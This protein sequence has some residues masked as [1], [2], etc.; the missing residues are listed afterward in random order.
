[1]PRPGDAGRLLKGPVLA[2][3]LDGT[4]VSVNTFPR[5]VLFSLWRLL[6]ERRWRA[7][8]RL[9]HALLRRKLLG[10][11][12]AVLKEVVHDVSLLLAHD[13]VRCW[14]EGLL[15]RHGRPAVVRLIRE[16]EGGTVL[17]TAAPQPYAVHFGELLGIDL[18][19][20]SARHAGVFA[21]NVAA[22]K[23]ARLQGSLSS[24][25]DCAVTDD[26]TIDGPLLA[27]ARRRLV[28]GPAG[29]LADY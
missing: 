22:A 9:L 14:A 13:A 7:W 25:L 17:C 3:D 4:L 16:W 6:L 5:F 26:S 27:L 24:P 15:A 28:V 29:V 8:F 19:Q 23:A 2:C 1:M 10:V 12:H 11:P 18:V 21:E 20:G